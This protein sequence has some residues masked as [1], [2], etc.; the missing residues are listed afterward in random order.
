[1]ASKYLKELKSIM[2]YQEPFSRIYAFRQYVEQVLENEK[3]TGSVY[4]AIENAFENLEIPDSIFREFGLLDIY[5]KFNRKRKQLGYNVPGNG[6]IQAIGNPYIRD[7]LAG[8]YDEP[9]KRVKK[10]ARKI[11][12]QAVKKDEKKKTPAKKIPIKTAPKTKTGEISTM[13]KI[14]GKKYPAGQPKEKK[15]DFARRVKKHGRYLPTGNEETDKRNL[16][17]RLKYFPN[18]FQINDSG[19]MKGPASTPPEEEKKKRKKKTEK[20]RLSGLSREEIDRMVEESGR[21]D[22]F[23]QEILEKATNMA[24]NIMINEM[25][26]PEY[27]DDLEVIFQRGLYMI[28]KEEENKERL[29]KEI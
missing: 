29:Y 8:R 19:T 25:D 26:K 7:V 15:D 24:I 16:Q 17:K 21:M 22:E 1:M 14:T 9:E 13:E 12:V 10:T 18:L 3:I 4:D 28:K 27:Q 11:K 20:S 2:S 5:V 6:D 23:E